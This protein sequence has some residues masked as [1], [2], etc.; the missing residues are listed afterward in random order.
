M[1]GA[2]RTDSMRDMATPE[3]RSRAARIGALSLHAQVDS[4]AHIRPAREAYEARFPRQVLETA[5][6][7]GETLTDEDV[8]LRAQ[9]LMRAH[10]LRLAQASARNRTKKSPPAAT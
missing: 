7:R 3:E 5:A 10:M 1:T 4:K 6:E 9:R 2:H 8:Q